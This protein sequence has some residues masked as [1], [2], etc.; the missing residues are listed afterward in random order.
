MT[1]VPGCGWGFHPF[2]TPLLLAAFCYLTYLIPHR[3]LLPQALSPARSD[4]LSAGDLC[5][6]LFEL[7]FKRH[8]LLAYLY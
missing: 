8:A 1:R 7:T 3:Y 4:A 6:L 2:K 5:C